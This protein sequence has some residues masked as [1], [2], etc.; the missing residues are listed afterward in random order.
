MADLLQAVKNLA[1]SLV[2]DEPKMA[3]HVGEVA[4][5][6]TQYVALAESLT[7][8][9][10]ALNTTTNPE[11]RKVV[12]EAHR[13]CD[14]QRER[15]EEFMKQEGVPLPEISQ[16]KPDSDPGSIPM[17]VKSS[18]EEIANALVLKITSGTAA[19]AAAAAQ[20]VRNDVGAMWLTFQ[21]EFVAFGINLKRLM[22]KHGW[23]K[24]PPLYVPP[25]S[26]IQ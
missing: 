11:L 23:L 6:W 3:L 1:G 9:R 8:E 20:C 21:S 15:L 10:I 13:M 7:A 5:C 26:P 25:G 2:D 4:A 22:R 18:D 12:E 24:I 19:Y 17:G 14:S 16:P